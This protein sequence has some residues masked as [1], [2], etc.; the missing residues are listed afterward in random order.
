MSTQQP[1]QGFDHRCERNVGYGLG[2]EVGKGLLFWYPKLA[3]VRTIVEDFWRTEHYRREYDIVYTPH[4][5]IEDLWARGGHIDH[6]ENRMYGLI[7]NNPSPEEQVRYR[8]RSMNCPLHIL[9]YGSAPR[10]RDELPIRL[11]ELGTVYRFERPSDLKYGMIRVRNYTPDDGHIFCRRDQVEEQVTSVLTFAVEMLRAFG[12]ESQH[13]NLR[14]SGDPE[15]DTVPPHE[16]QWEQEVLREAARRV[17]RGKRMLSKRGNPLFYGVKLD[18]EIKDFRGRPWA[19]STVQVDT[20]LPRQFDLSYQAGKRLERPVIIHRT[21]LGSLER[22]V[23]LLIEHCKGNLPA[24]LC[25]VQVIVIPVSEERNSQYA[26][27]V[28]D[29]LKM[30]DIRV[31]LDARSETLERRKRDAHLERVPY[32][33]VVGDRETTNNTVTISDRSDR[34]PTEYLI[35]DFIARVT[36]EGSKPRLQ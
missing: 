34:E 35:D 15:A 33:A 2:Q 16:S 12:F 3:R 7:T 36:A 29:R 31:K 25:P 4:I 28:I 6:F 19:C 20:Y 21:L 14:L 24:W 1:E 30:H 11:A 18:L 22:F 10:Q 17:L 32:I 26:R 23:A 9:V 27:E 8:L 13:Y 5:G